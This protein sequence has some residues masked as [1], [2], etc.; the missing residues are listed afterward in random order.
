MQNKGLFFGV[1]GSINQIYQDEAGN[2]VEC[3]F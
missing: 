2:S 1:Y 3:N